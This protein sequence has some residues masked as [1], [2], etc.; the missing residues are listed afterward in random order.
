ML[1]KTLYTIL[2]LNN[3]ATKTRIL[4]ALTLSRFL[5]QPLQQKQN[6][7]G[8]SSLAAPN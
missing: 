1:F 5:A 7:K 8:R 2:F 4:A 6:S 3:S